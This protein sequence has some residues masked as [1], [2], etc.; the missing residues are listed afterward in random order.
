MTEGARRYLEEGG[1]REIR[2]GVEKGKLTDVQ[3]LG[4]GYVCGVYGFKH[5]T[6]PGGPVLKQRQGEERG[7]A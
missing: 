4:D 6:E 5:G 3:Q 7:M 2:R 1:Q